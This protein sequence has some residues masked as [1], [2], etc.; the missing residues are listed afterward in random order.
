MGQRQRRWEWG[1]GLGLG[2][3][4]VLPL[5]LALAQQPVWTVPQPATSIGGNA[6]TTVVG[7]GTSDFQ[8]VW[9]STASNEPAKQRHGCTIQNNSAANPMW[10]TE[11]LG[12]AAS[13]QAK[14]LKLGAGQSYYCNWNGTVLI[15]EID[16]AGTSGDAFYAAQ[17]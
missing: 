10:V 17:Y 11:G 6:S 5:G 12:T 8:R 15:G 2:L 4:L 1:L 3:V 14:G 16:L 9:P 13:T 7:P